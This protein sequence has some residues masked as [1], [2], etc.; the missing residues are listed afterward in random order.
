MNLH[1]SVQY[2]KGVG[3][4]RAAALRRLGLHTLGDLIGHVPRAY[5]DWQ[6]ITPIADAPLGAPVCV[7][8]RV[9]YAPVEHHIRTGMTLYKTRVS[10]ETGSLAV[11]LFNTGYQAARLR[12][13]EEYLFYGKITDSFYAREMSAPQ[14]A[15]VSEARLRPVYPLTEGFSSRQIE[16]LVLQAMEQAGAQIVEFLPEEIL[17][18]YN[19]MGRAEALR[20]IHRPADWEEARRARRR[21][22]FNELITLQLGLRLLREGRAGS[23][24]TPLPP[25]P[26]MEFLARLPFEPTQA[27]T[28]ATREAAQSL[29][30]PLPMRRLLQGDVGSGKTAV[31]AALLHQ[32][33]RAGTQ[34]AMMAPT[35]LL[36][37]QHHETLTKLGLEPALLIGSTPAAQKKAVKAALAEG[38]ILLIVGTHALLEKDVRFADL[39]LVIVDEQHRFGVEQRNQL[40]VD[41][42]QLTVGVGADQSVNCQLSTVNCQLSTVNCQLPHTLV[43]SATPIPRSLA[44]IIY[45]DLDISILDELPPG[46]TPVETYQVSSGYR[47][48]AYNYVKKHLDQGRQGYIVC[49]RVHPTESA[50]SSGTPN[51]EDEAGELS[52]AKQF[53]EQLSGG[54]F[55]GYSLGLLHGRLGAKQK[56][57]AMRAFAAGETQLLV[58]TTVIEVGVDVPNAVI[59]VV[60]NA[61]RFGLSQLHQLRGRIGRGAGKS[62]CILISDAENEEAKSR[63]A[64]MKETNDG[65]EIARRDLELRG[66]GEFFG[67][68]Q[69]GLPPLRLADLATDAELLAETKRAAAAIAENDPDLALPEH[70]NL[71]KACEKLFSNK[72]C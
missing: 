57:E 37:R 3:E 60:E 56:E 54:D 59:M 68:R 55:A 26:A 42:G 39:A 41:S 65:F 8:A 58:A 6:N 2:L 53:Y 44:M 11:T 31:A 72:T 22:A 46:R 52:S 67:A 63:F 29:S 51:K 62:T 23:G 47:A 61:E 5:E 71:K 10:D 28:R 49:P 18:E 27:Q 17:T 20:A 66:P 69:H 24:A 40:T 48:R 19:L 45:G 13:N 38:S 34:A 4:K 33:A 50:D 16:S 15:P 14:F 7:R 1:T 32:A 12:E 36:A 30:E 21:L 35:E 25:E 64:I 70:Q 43:M 9:D